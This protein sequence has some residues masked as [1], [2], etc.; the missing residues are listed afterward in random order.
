MMSGSTRSVL[1]ATKSAVAVS[2]GSPRSP[3][4]PGGG[5]GSGGADPLLAVDGDVE[6]AVRAT[7]AAEETVDVD[8]V[9]HA[10]GTIEQLGHL[11]GRGQELSHPSRSHRTRFSAASHDQ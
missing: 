3:P 7:R 2:T 11:D 10:G 5:P 4:P 8:T 6:V 9:P 1:F